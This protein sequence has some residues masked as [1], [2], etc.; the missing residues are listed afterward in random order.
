MTTFEG[1]LTPA[2]I[3]RVDMPKPPDAPDVSQQ[4]HAVVRANV[5]DRVLLHVTNLAI[6][7]FYTLTALGL[8]M[9]VVGSG[10]HIARGPSG[11]A[12]DSWAH[13]TA[14]VTLGGGDG[15]DLLVD[16]TGLAAGTY[17]LY[18]S[19]LNFL[20]NGA[21]EDRGGLMTTFVLQ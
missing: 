2:G 13:G 16:T 9:K 12:A 4:Q 7:G 20:S 3:P 17:Y 15:V 10:A 8:P 14:S 21:L 6:D 18:T 19:N 1:P 11:L 5:G